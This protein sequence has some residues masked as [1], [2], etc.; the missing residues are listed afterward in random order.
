MINTIRA[1]KREL[2][3]KELSE[4]VM[5]QSY[6]AILD[7][8]DKRT[9]DE[10]HDSAS[11]GLFAS[12]DPADLTEA[13]TRAV[14]NYRR[15]IYDAWSVLRAGNIIVQTETKRYI[16]NY[17]VLE[18]A[19][20][21]TASKSARTVE[22]D[23]EK[24]AKIES[25]IERFESGKEPRRKSAYREQEAEWDADHKAVCRVVRET[26]RR[27]RD[28]FGRIKQQLERM[29]ELSQSNLALKRL[30]KRNMKREA[31]LARHCVTGSSPS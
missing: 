15:R 19:A 18:S 31:K 4:L 6:K 3:Y 1:S 25:F 20:P 22:V 10:S 24:L 12:R 14:E 11:S 8:V 17:E 2:T 7:E 9:G 26:E 30:I 13:Q 27:C 23:A 29:Q 5:E 16:Y 28:S 21:Q